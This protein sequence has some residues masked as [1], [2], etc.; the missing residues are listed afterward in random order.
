MNN[1][2]LAAVIGAVGVIVASLITIYYSNPKEPVK[3]SNK[4]II[5]GVVTEDGTN[6]P[7]GQAHIAIVG[8]NESDISQDNGNFKIIILGEGVKTV[9]LRVSKK[10]YKVVDLS[11][12]VP[13]ESV[14]I[15]M[16]RGK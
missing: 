9:R 16:V 5:A 7:I 13:H 8:R 15:Q 11:F 4:I 3:E 14:Q 12:D 10:Q 1:N 2:I 6:N